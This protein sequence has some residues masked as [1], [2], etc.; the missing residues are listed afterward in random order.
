MARCAIIERPSPNFDARRCAVDMLVLHYTGMPTGEAAL[1]RLCDRAAKVSAHYLIE[2]DGRVFRLV[3]EGA[4]AWHAGVAR[5]S[6]AG[7]VN[8]RAIGIELVNPGHDWG[9]RPFAPAQMAALADLCR[10]ILARHAIPPWHV[11]GHSDVAPTRKRDP[12]ELFDWAWLAARGVGLWV[13]TEPGAQGR[14]LTAPE[15]RRLQTALAAFGY[16]MPTTGRQSRQ[17]NAVVCAFHAHFRPAAMGWPAD[18]IS[19]SL[20]EALLARQR[21]SPPSVS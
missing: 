7:D 13:D 12:G 14:S 9:Y 4:R 2:D 10:D 20:I 1:A 15:W 17:A 16:D 21:S 8:S 5:W 11:L 6:G 3:A 19:L 18:D